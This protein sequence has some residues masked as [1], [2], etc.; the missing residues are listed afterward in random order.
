MGPIV[1]RSLRPSFACCPRRSCLRRAKLTCETNAQLGANSVPADSS[2][3]SKH[4]TH[5]YSASCSWSGD[6]GLG[7]ERYHRRHT[8]SAS[9]ATQLLDMSSDPAFRGE[10]NLLN[11]E[12]LL[13]MAAAT[14]QLLSFLAVAARAG[15][16]VRRYRDEAMAEMPEDEKPIKLSSVQLRPCIEC[17]VGPTEQRVQ[18]LVRQAHDECYIANSLRT[19]VT[20]D[21]TIIF[22]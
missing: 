1:P 11:P 2:S 8:A 21:A 22:I 12:Q 10:P 19:V 3:M 17:A 4:K 14:C 6:T 18:E 7:Y 15:V 5:H 9:P 16:T 20:V 13:V